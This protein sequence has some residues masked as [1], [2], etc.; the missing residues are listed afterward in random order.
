MDMLSI[1]ILLVKALLIFPLFAFYVV[2]I[3]A[4]V[5]ASRQGDAKAR[6]YWHISGYAFVA[7]GVLIDIERWTRPLPH[8]LSDSLARFGMMLAGLGMGMYIAAIIQRKVP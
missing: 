3:F 8:H 2:A 4:F 6:L 1:K 5:S 7:T